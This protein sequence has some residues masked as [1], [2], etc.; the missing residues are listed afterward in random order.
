MMMQMML[1]HKVNVRNQTTDPVEK[2]IIDADVEYLETKKAEFDANPEAGGEGLGIRPMEGLASSVAVCASIDI[3]LILKKKRIELTHYEVELQTERKDAT[4]APFT[5]IHLMFTIGKED[6]IEQVKKAVAL[7][8][9]KY[10]SVSASLDPTI[11]ITH[12][13]RTLN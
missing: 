8:V 2:A 13:V 12:E 5:K 9:E 11:I 4:P 6:P 7:G 10:C 1:G 3:I